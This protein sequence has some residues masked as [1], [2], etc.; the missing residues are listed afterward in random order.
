MAMKQYPSE[1]KA[2]AVALYR[3]REH[4]DWLVARGDRPLG[5]RTVTGVIAPGGHRTAD[6]PRPPLTGAAFVR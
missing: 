4:S 6:R 1:F 2:E 3:S 5:P